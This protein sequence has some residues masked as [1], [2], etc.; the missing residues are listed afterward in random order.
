MTE[1]DAPHIAEQPPASGSSTSDGSSNQVTVDQQIIDSGDQLVITD[2]GDLLIKAP[3]GHV[4]E[5]V[6]RGHA[7]FSR[8]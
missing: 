7:L 4:V 8:C 3:H 5:N 2:W 1:S 6:I